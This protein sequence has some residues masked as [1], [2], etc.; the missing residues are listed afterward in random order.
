LPRLITACAVVLVLALGA[1]ACGGD[2]GDD[3]G[4]GGNGGGD[5]ASYD[6][7]ASEVIASTDKQ[8]ILDDFAADNPECQ[9]AIDQGFLLDISARATNLPPD[10]PIAPEI[11]D[12]CTPTTN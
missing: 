1:A 2:D 12:A 6:N 10:A 8:A 4:N 5:G 9:G 11:L 3:G 7:T